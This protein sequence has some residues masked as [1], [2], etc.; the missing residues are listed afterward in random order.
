M[1]IPVRGVSS[2]VL[3]GMWIPDSVLLYK[4]IF[5]L[6]NIKDV[7][8]DELWSNH[9]KTNIFTEEKLEPA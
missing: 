8:E 6:I 2:F 7:G 9:E 4:W 3:I 5:S 1:Y